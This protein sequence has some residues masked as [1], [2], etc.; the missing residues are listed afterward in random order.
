MSMPVHHSQV[1]YWNQSKVTEE[2]PPGWDILSQ[3]ILA[4]AKL[5]GELRD[6]VFPSA[7]RIQ[8]V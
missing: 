4:L 1:S 2:R 6:D 8:Q 7:Q 5:S 3:S